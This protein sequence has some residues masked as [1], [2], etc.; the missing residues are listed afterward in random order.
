MKKL[1]FLIL[2][3]LI[4]GFSV[5]NASVIRSA[6]SVSSDVG[7]Y[8]DLLK[9]QTSNIIDQSGLLENYISGSTDFD[10]YTNKN[11]MHE[12][13]PGSAEEKPNSIEWFAPL[14]DNTATIDF[15]LSDIF[16]IDRI[17]IWNEDSWGIASVEILFTTNADFSSL[18][19]AGSFYIDSNERKKTYSAQILDLGKVYDASHIRFIVENT[20]NSV[21]LGE[22][23]FSTIP[24][25]S[26]LALFATGF[27][28]FGFVR[29][30]KYS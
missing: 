9:Y 6:E 8:G 19:S 25:P 15:V 21:S 24:E 28:G 22:V 14:K 5:V 2:V 16:S 4:S 18:V 11:V 29:R 7:Y 20:V 17:A 12:Y 30:K 10:L 1:Y 27:I 26:V 13:S 23:A 3:L